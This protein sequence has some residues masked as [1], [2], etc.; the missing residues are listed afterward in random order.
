MC[1]TTK[2]ALRVAQWTTGNVA[3]EAVKAILARPDLVLDVFTHLMRV[4][5]NE[6]RCTVD[7]AHTTKDVLNDGVS[8]PAGHVGDTDIKWYVTADGH[9]VLAV[10]QR[11][12]A[13]EFFDP[14]WTEEHGYRI[15]IRGD[16]LV[17]VEVDMLPT[18]DDLA[19]LTPQRMRGIGLRITAARLVNAI[20][21]VCAAAP[22]IATYADLP[23]IP[24]HLITG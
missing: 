7:F 2:P 15:E 4:N 3:R 1:A 9:E 12:I 24:A 18:D 20:P 22:G 23:A 21:V 6:T 11:W 5:L 13:T 10:N 17:Y 19:D 16:P 14:P 8:L